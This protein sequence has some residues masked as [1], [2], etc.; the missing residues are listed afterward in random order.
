MDTDILKILEM[1]R[2]KHAGHN[3]DCQTYYDTC[4]F[5]QI[6]VDEQTDKYLTAIEEE[7]KP[8]VCGHWKHW[9]RNGYAIA[10]ESQPE[11]LS[12]ILAFN[13]FQNWLK[14]KYFDI[15]LS[16]EELYRHPY[17]HQKILES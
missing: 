5:C 13:A 14:P 12:G 10:N 16:N 6:I 17:V 1:F 8:I 7:F 11:V 3:L 9:E 15:E 2:L 4:P